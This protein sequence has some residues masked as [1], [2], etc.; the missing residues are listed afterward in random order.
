MAD[1]KKSEKR[2]QKPDPAL[3]PAIDRRF[4]QRFHLSERELEIA[5]LWFEHEKIR[6][7][8]RQL[9][10]DERTVRNHK[11]HLY[12]K[13]QVHSRAEF[14]AAVFVYLQAQPGDTEITPPFVNF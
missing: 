14:V 4:A 5:Q 7:I 9:E 10:I 3:T 8:A 2:P 6:A 12:V 1:F 13:M 11:E